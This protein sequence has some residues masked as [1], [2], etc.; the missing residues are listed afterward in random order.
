MSGLTG[1]L[2]FK[3]QSLSI[4]ILLSLLSMNS[5]KVLLNFP[6]L[7]M[8]KHLPFAGILI[9]T[10]KTFLAT[11]V[12]AKR[13]EPADRDRLPTEVVEILVCLLSPS[14][15]IWEKKKNSYRAILY[16][17]IAFPLCRGTRFDD[18]AKQWSL[19]WGHHP[20]LNG[21]LSSGVLVWPPEDSYSS[22]G[23]PWDIPGKGSDPSP[24]NDQVL[25]TA[26]PKQQWHNPPQVEKNQTGNRSPPSP[27]AW[28]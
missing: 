20:E 2:L 25:P 27:Y 1:L 26:E 5:A 14:L 23:Y 28:L 11:G 21:N 9:V 6:L 17:L 7:S 24:F 22:S 13:V 15:K 19:A 12:V 10:A 3:P 16:A 8:Q 4:F 18:R